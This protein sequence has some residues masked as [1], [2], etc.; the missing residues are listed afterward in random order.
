MT[1]LEEN[2]WSTHLCQ[3]CGSGLRRE[4]H[5]LM[6]GGLT[7]DYYSDLCYDEGLKRAMVSAPVFVAPA[8]M[9]LR[10]RL[11]RSMQSR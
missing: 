1:D 5:V 7:E 6:R 4:R 3:N 9:D 10:A 8:R 11:L 2:C